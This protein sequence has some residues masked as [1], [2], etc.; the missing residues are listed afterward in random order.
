VLAVNSNG[1]IRLLKKGFTRREFLRTAAVGGIVGT[2]GGAL[3]LSQFKNTTE[4][5]IAK[6]SNYNVDFSSIIYQGLAELGIKKEE[7]KGKSVLLKPNLVEVHAKA[8]HINT[9]PLVVRG[10][11]EAFLRLGA[12]KVFVGEGQGHVRDSLLVYEESGM[13]DILYEDK[14]PFL[15][16]NC[17]PVSTVK[18]C[19]RFSELKTLSFPQIF[20]KIDFIVS[21]A[22]MKTHHWAGVTLS[23]KNIFGV[24]PG[25]VYGWPKNVLHQVGIERAILDI[26]ATIKPHFA[27]IDGVVGME[28]DGPIMGDPRQAGILVMGRNLAAA[29]LTA[30]RTMGIDPLKIPYLNAA[31][32][33]FKVDE[34]KQRGNEIYDVRVNFLLKE[35]IP[36]HKAL[37]S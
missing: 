32:K 35:N 12:A 31:A 25:I 7:I 17:G 27:I 15:D 14:I 18:N 11:V 2:S 22:K 21:M 24:M 9:H 37:I 30:T 23:M 20:N 29:D 33:L 8:D 5:F 34:V 19:G 26:N 1:D 16:L 10:A 6:A 28:G 3:L 4:T 36:A 13:A